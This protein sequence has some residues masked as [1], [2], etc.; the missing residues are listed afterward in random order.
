MKKSFILSI[1]FSLFF[2]SSCDT[3]KGDKKEDGPDFDQS[4]MLSNFSENIILPSFENLVLQ[5]QELGLAADSF[6]LEKNQ[7][8]LEVLQAQ[9]KQ[10]YLAWQQVSHLEFGPSDA[11]GIRS[12]VNIFP[13]NTSLIEQ[14]IQKGNSVLDALGNKAAKGFPALDYL[15]HKD[16]DSALLVAFSDTKRTEYLLKVVEDLSSKIN[17]VSTDWVAYKS[18]FNNATGT[19]VGSS[20]GMLINALNQHYERF[21]RD[22]KIG[23]PLGVRSSGTARPQDSEAFYAGFSFDLIAANYMAMKEL[24]IGADGIGLDD[25][26]IASGAEDIDEVIKS[27]MVIIESK[28]NQFNTTMP[29]AIQNQNS[30]LLSTYQEIQKLIVYWKVDMPSRLGILI[31]YQDNDGD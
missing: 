1:V 18:T 21:F 26:L 17:K 14:N 3:N 11:A 10:T 4:A 27:Q 25:Y 15:I 7:R 24:Y 12:N 9:F 30:E 23:I 13:T 6:G 20:A 2:I 29:Q 22:G 8:T 19:D 31:T 28:L 16:N 5:T